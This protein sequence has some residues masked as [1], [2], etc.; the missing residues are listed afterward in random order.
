MRETYY[1]GSYWGCRKDSAEE[2]ARRAEAF[3]HLLSQCDPIYTHWFE[4][5][6]SLKKA[7]QLQFEPTCETFV[8]FFK[9]RKYQE[10]R[11][12]FSFSA[13]TGHKEE[14]RGGLVTLHCGSAA[15]FS[16]NNCLLYL[17]GEEAEVQR[18]LEVTVLEKVLRAM[19]MAWEPDWAVVTSD[20]LR[21]AL[22][23]TSRAGTFVGWMTYLSR[24]R[25][26]VPALPE[27]VRVQPVEDKG[28]LLLLTPERLTASNPE[29]LALGRHVQEVLSAR[30]LLEP[31]VSRRP[32]T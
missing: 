31:V 28:T 30:G 8:R 1:T 9:K 15:E 10:G 19:I 25:G 27:P 21:G 12:G 29:H 3:F 24:S 7:L 13:W 20:E 26:E 16:S 2:C 23:Q 22:S 11:D 14:D 17:P 18:V 4:Q 5:A 32:A 6:D